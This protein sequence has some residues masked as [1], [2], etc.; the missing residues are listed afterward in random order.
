MSFHQICEPDESG[1]S[2]IIL[3][4]EVNTNI[5]YFQREISAGQA[6][7]KIPETDFPISLNYCCVIFPFI[8]GAWFFGSWFIVR[9]N[10]DVIYLNDKVSAGSKPQA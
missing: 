7:L 9:Q 5:I 6:N 2:L 3:L 10:F 4:P 1:Y 8:P